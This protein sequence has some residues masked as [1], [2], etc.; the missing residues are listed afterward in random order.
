MATITPIWTSRSELA[1]LKISAHSLFVIKAEKF[2][3]LNCYTVWGSTATERTVS[4]TLAL[5]STSFPILVVGDF[6]IHYPSAEPLRSHN[7][8]ELQASFPYFSRAAEFG[9]TLLNTLGV[10]TRFPLKGS[11][12][13]SVLDLAFAATTLILFFQEWA[14]DLP[15]PGSDHVPIMIKLA[16]QITTPPP[17]APNWI[18]TDWASLE[19]QLKEARVPSPPDLLTRNA[20]ENWFNSHLTTLV[21]LLK[22]HT[23][24]CRPSITVKLWWS[25]LLTKLWKECHSSSRK[26]QASNAPQDR[27][28]AELSK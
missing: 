20:F 2:H 19:P 10:H 5:P 27:A 17:L 23:P 26:A 24:L 21:P 8:S 4:P 6:N 7:F 28:A 16:N 13:S 3:I 9:Y 12:R 14:T 15:S 25:P 11:F 1:T 22:A 18:R